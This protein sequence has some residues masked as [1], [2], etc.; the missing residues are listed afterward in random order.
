MLGSVVS[1]THCTLYSLQEILHLFSFYILG[2]R[3]IIHM[4]NYD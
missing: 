4:H 2:A 3:N 1:G